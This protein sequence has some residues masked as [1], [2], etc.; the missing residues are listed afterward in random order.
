MT[1]FLKL[2][3]FY[4]SLA[5][6][7]AAR[8]KR[9]EETLEASQ[10]KASSSSKPSTFNSISSGK[11]NPKLEELRN[12]NLRHL[13]K[14]A[15]SSHERKSKPKVTEPE[16]SEKSRPKDSRRTADKQSAAKMDFKE[17][18]KVA[19]NQIDE[20]PSKPAVINYKQQRRKKGSSELH[21]EWSGSSNAVESR[22]GDALSLKAEKQHAKEAERREMLEREPKSN[23]GKVGKIP[24]KAAAPAVNFRD[25]MDVA[26]QQAGKSAA[27]KKDVA[28]K[29]QVH[30]DR[31]QS[32]KKPVRAEQKA[33]LM[34]INSIKTNLKDVSSEKQRRSTEQEK[35]RSSKC[36]L[37]TQTVKSQ[38]NYSSVREGVASASRRQDSRDMNGNRNSGDRNVGS[39]MKRSKISTIDEELE[40]ERRELEKKR[41]ILK[42][43]MQ[44]NP[45]QG[46]EASDF[47]EY[48]EDDYD[49][50]E[51]TDFIDDGGEDLDYSKH[52][53]NIF[54]Y[55]R[56]R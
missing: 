9:I 15:S 35:Q 51:M 3:Y 33:R 30:A 23:G 4:Y 16:K 20:A 18:M 36:T 28:S 10:T 22:K 54:G 34:D 27:R 6:Q 26:K 5:A 41:N 38:N 32:S 13:K 2:T 56:R 17:L 29:Q 53:R 43:K 25:L 44:G 52:I 31:E 1:V 39:T 7:Y 47:S 55:D 37:V 49:D 8:K 45:P 21:F 19:K 24:K 11:V 14:P 48:S 50:E 46:G 42:R 12:Q 40:L